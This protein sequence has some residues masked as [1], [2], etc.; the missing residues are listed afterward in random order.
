MVVVFPNAV[1]VETSGFFYKVGERRILLDMT[2]LLGVH[3]CPLRSH[4]N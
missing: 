4:G 2:R 3:A 1:Q